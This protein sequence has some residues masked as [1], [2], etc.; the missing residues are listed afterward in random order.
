MRLILTSVLLLLICLLPSGVSAGLILN[1]ILA[2]EPGSATTLE[3]V[4]ILN[5]PDTGQAL[6][7][8]GYKFIDGGESVT[9]IADVEIPA[10]G[11]AVLA[12]KATGPASFEER[13][14]NASGVWGDVATESYPLI[15]V[16]QMSL[17]N[18]TDTLRLVSPSGDTS[19]I[20]WQFDPGDGV[21][22]E[23]I[24][25]GVNDAESNFASAR[26]PSGS[27][28]GRANSVLPPPGDLAIDT[29]VVG[30]LSPRASDAIH[31]AVRIRNVG[32]GDA[33][34]GS[35]ILGL[36]S[37]LIATAEFAAIPEGGEA[38]AL[39]V[40]PDPRPGVNQLLL[41]IS[42]DSDSS[43]N[44]CAIPLT[45]R[46]DRPYIVVSE[47]L[48]NPEPGGPEEW[49]EIVNL[50][51]SA[52][53]LEGL[54]VG[55]S[56]NTEPIPLSAGEIPSSAYWILAENET[57]FRGFY[58]AFDGTVLQIAGWR[59]LNNSG[60]GIRLIGP[61]GEII[62][63]LSFRDVYPDNRSVE[64]VELLPALAPTGDWTGSVA[65]HGATPGAANSVV[66][67]QPGALAL[68]SVWILAGH[69]DVLTIYSSITN[70]GFGPTFA[71]DLYIGLSLDPGVPDVVNDTIAVVAFP[72]L[73]ESQTVIIPSAWDSPPPGIYR[74]VVWTTNDD[75]SPTE[76]PG[77]AFTTV[78]FTR[79]LLIVSEY[80]PVPGPNGPGEW[81]ELYNASEIPLSLRG[82]R[83][84]DSNGVVAL[85]AQ[86]ATLS[87]G[88]F[89]VV[90]QDEDQFRAFYT[91]F[92]GDLLVPAGWRTLGDSGDRIR[93]LG[94]SDEII[95]SVT[96]A[97]VPGGNRSVERR[98]LVPEF[99]DPRDWGACIALAR[100]TPGNSNS[101]RR[102][103]H[104]LAV[105]SVS[106]A[107]TQVA[108]PE[109][110]TGTVWVTNT[111]FM[112][113]D[114]STLRITDGADGNELAHYSTP[115]L[116]S[117]GSA[118]IAYEIGPLPP[119]RHAVYFVLEQ[120]E[121][122][123]NNVAL[124]STL[125]EHSFPAIIITE[126]LADPETTGPGEWIEL[127]NASDLPLTLA[128]CAIGDATSYADL[129][130]PSGAKLP[131]SEYQVACQDSEAFRAW[132]PDFDGTLLEVDPWR[133]LNNTGDGIRLRGAAGELIDSLTFDGGSGN[134]RSRERLLLSA[135]HSSPDGWTMSVDHSGA[136][137]GRANSVNAASAGS[138]EVSV[139]PNPVFRSAGQIARIDYRLEIGENLTLK[140]FDRAGRLVRAIANQVPS[141]TGFI[142]WDGTDDDGSNLRPGPYVLL[143]K[144]EPAGSMKKLVVVIAP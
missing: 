80:M 112:E 102:Q 68:D 54:R 5:W 28:P 63:S 6:S 61:S 1:E 124:K 92:D 128:S 22:V 131:P 45:T 73:D 126:F 115:Y 88:S 67:G 85:P 30:P 65:A 69:P 139:S 90:A 39:L 136:T 24:R 58:P 59:A 99:A 105:D 106:M 104:D 9:L 114:E 42:E 119:G 7:P 103:L 35:I 47:Y 70:V 60:D 101:I 26:D 133:E 120:D 3:W 49:I 129:V 97:A 143:A 36:G 100:G 46:F 109:S 55:D 132:Y 43:N 13:W 62:D 16:A 53:S 37:Q 91:D 12:R 141:A 44:S 40:W 127:Y 20:I 15:M 72:A 96:Y 113:T 110:I 31:F 14:G 74:V 48:A 23:R 86:L 123:G 82:I 19:T 137:P 107:Q 11:F 25:P 138:L 79:P 51:G 27:T 89:L 116:E 32:F 140:I 135:T 81:I 71:R 117:Y 57:A 56:L 75:G 34:T 21:S 98:L 18:S 122:G 77:I 95:D 76:P 94:P 142:E 108:W 33:S 10:G 134:N 78:P 8:S 118:A 29:V 144:S 87:P 121:F 66:R 111:G 84:G 38:V 130:P 83:I 50:S 52:I 2:N 4:E 125:I 64:R 93:L 41:R 17:R